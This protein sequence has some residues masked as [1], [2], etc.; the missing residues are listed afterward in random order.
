MNKWAKE[1]VKLAN[2]EG[3]L[4]KLF[5]VYPVELSI[6]RKIPL[7]TELKIRKALRNKNKL[8]LIC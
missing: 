7:E 8:E 4:D 6:D 5:G 1:S 2:S 3:Y